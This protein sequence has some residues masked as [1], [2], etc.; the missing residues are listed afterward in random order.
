MDRNV[1]TAKD[2]LKA[3]ARAR[4]AVDE[5]RKA[6]GLSERNPRMGALPPSVKPDQALARLVKFI[7]AEALSLYM[8]LA[9]IA[10]TAQP[11]EN[12]ALYWLTFLLFVTAIFNALYLYIIWNVRRGSQIFVSTISLIV[13]AV[14]T[15]GPLVQQLKFPP[16]GSTLALTLVTAFLCFFQPPEDAREKIPKR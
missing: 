2:A 15:N 6:E 11:A 8:A 4:A 16:I 10:A 14:A 1:I 12:Q 7:P 9:G 3:N 13:Y 5:K